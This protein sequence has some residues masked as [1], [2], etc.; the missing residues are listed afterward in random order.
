MT[1]KSTTFSSICK[2][3]TDGPLYHS[4]I[5]TISLGS[6][7]SLD[8]YHPIKQDEVQYLIMI[9]NIKLVF[10]QATSTS[11]ES[12]YL[13]SLLLE[14]CSLLLLTG[15]LYNEYLHGIAE[16]SS[17]IVDKNVN[18]IDQLSYSAHSTV[19]RTTRVSLT[20]RHVPK[21]LKVKLKL[22]KH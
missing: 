11:L 8:F 1:Y 21:L 13:S 18:N 3:H 2:P 20:I 17:D 12:R 7:T 15:D 10:V 14:P 19:Q 22:A 5:A 4:V 16:R 9:F 6:S